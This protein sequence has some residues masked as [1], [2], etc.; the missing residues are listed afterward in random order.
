MRTHA[1]AF[2]PTAA[3]VALVMVL[4]G[5]GPVL[6]DMKKV[7][8]PATAGLVGEKPKPTEKRGTG[9]KTKKKIKRTCKCGTSRLFREKD[10]LQLS[11]EG[12]AT[13]WVRGPR[14]ALAL[15]TGGGPGME[16]TGQSTAPIL[17][18]F[19]LAD[20]GTPTASPLGLFQV[21]SDLP[22]GTSLR[23]ALLRG[24]KG[25]IFDRVGAEVAPLQ[26]PDAPA[27]TGL[28]L[29]ARMEVDNEICGAFAS[30]PLRVEEDPEK[31][32]LE[33]ILV[34]R[35]TT[36]GQ[37]EA[38]LIERRQAEIYGLGRVPSCEHGMVL[39]AGQ[40]YTLSLYPLGAGFQ[41]GL[42]WVYQ[43]DP[44]P[45]A[46]PTLLE[47]IPPAARADHNLFI[48]MRN[49]GYVTVDGPRDRM[50]FG[51]MVVVVGGA[52]VAGGLFF[53]TRR[54]RRRRFAQLQC[55]ECTQDLTI[56]LLD[57]NSDGMFCIQCGGASVLVKTNE[58]GQK[59]A[60]AVR[61]GTEAGAKGAADAGPRSNP[62]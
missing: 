28:W 14:D 20:Y 31:S 54:R 35:T 45:T 39:P 27:P 37:K 43:I 32:R 53:V 61:L 30:F 60:I 38:A 48:E 57:P 47:P 16:E 34:V 58:K 3:L 25:R 10:G 7:E 5:S 22:P 44:A 21:G 17:L 52:T 15:F 59:E 9:P 13:A 1:T 56:D 40:A 55:P 11:A 18:S 2:L 46:L 33:G 4:L 41:V 12:G 36:E 19:P 51:S 24:K 49:Q 23:V 50:A 6:A 29:G 62:S 8:P 42:P 26:V